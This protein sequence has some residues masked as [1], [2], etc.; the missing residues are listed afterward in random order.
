MVQFV[1][2]IHCGHCGFTHPTVADVR[3]CA[4]G[5]A[6]PSTG[7]VTAPRPV[8][9]RQLDYIRKLHGDATYAS[10]LTVEQAS[11]YIKRLKRNKG[12][13]VTTREPAV[14]QT[15]STPAAPPPP[16]PRRPK[17][18]LKV[19]KPML[20]SVPD[21]YYAVQLDATK[22]TIFFRVS[23]PKSGRFKGALKVQTQ[24]S[25]NYELYAVIWPSGQVSAYE[26]RWQDELTILAIDYNSASISYGQKIGRCMRCNK[27]LTD[28]R[29]RW[30]GIGPEC[31][32][33]WPHIINLVNDKK[34]VFQL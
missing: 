19:P 20:E 27:E 28:E 25:E 13:G 14:S 1:Q 17:I 3:K 23:R 10:K 24:H 30:Y 8:S 31:E 12:N 33:V 5:P 6:R 29:S 15:A 18:E 34:G 21:G 32:Q 7:N 11:A 26:S 2:E 16:A 9:E 4:A 22:P